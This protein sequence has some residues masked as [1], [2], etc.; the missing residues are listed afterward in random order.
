MI[1][2]R[3]VIDTA[4]TP[5][6][7]PVITTSRLRLPVRLQLNFTVFTNFRLRCHEIHFRIRNRIPLNVGSGQNIA[8]TLTIHR[9]VFKF[10]ALISARIVRR[11]S[12]LHD[13]LRSLLEVFSSFLRNLPLIV[14]APYHPV[15]LQT[16]LIKLH[17]SLQIWCKSLLG[18]FPQRMLR[19]RPRIFRGCLSK[20]SALKLSLLLTSLVIP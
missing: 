11:S 13:L 20:F 9:M 12:I 5:H 16:L 1:M 14:L 4:I 17:C 8:Y 2:I 7:Q 6:Y 10:P 18:V 3:A 19:T 15:V